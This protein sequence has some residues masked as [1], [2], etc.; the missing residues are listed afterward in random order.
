MGLKRLFLIL[1]SLFSSVFGNFRD[2][3]TKPPC[4][5][6]PIPDHL[7]D[8]IWKPDTT[9]MSS[10]KSTT[11]VDNQVLLL[12]AHGDVSYSTKISTTVTCQFNLKAFPFD[13]QT[14]NL[15]LYS[16]GHYSD[17]IKLYWDE[18]PNI[19]YEHSI[20]SLKSFYLTHYATRTLR[21]HN[22]A[23]CSINGTNCRAKNVLIMEFEFRR[24]SMTIL[25]S[26]YSISSNRG[27]PL[28]QR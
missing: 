8:V 5:P 21:V 14:C 3:F 24:Y 6:L 15:E 12:G 4:R 11:T 10:K 16:F 7:T 28:K 27:R 23:Y 1:F 25:V 22:I 17:E 9:I 2:I 26:L 13:G 19:F 18:F 20:D